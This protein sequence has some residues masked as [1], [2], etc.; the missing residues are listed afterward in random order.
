[1]AGVGV[2][3]YNAISGAT[4]VSNTI[5]FNAAEGVW[6]G[7]ADE[8]LLVRNSVE[9]NGDGIVIEGA[10]LAQAYANHISNNVI[11]SND[12][13]GVVV[14][15]DAA[16]GNTIS[17]NVITGNGG[18][19]ISLES[20][21]NQGI[22]AP[23]INRLSHRGSNI[24]GTANAADGSIVEVFA[25]LSDEGALFLGQTTV[26]GGY[27][28][29]TT[30]VPAGMELHATVS[31]PDGN[32]SEFGPADLYGPPM[33]DTV[34]TSTRDGNEEIYLM[35]SGLA[36][37]RRLTARP[38]ADNN[39]RLCK[40]GDEVVFASDALGS[41]DIWWVNS[42]G[43]GLEQLTK[44]PGSEFEPAC[45]PAGDQLAYS[46]GRDIF[47]A[48][49]GGAP[50]PQELAY[51]DG[52][53][54]FGYGN[55]VGHAYGVH[56]TRPAAAQGVDAASKPLATLR[57]WI[58]ADPAEFQWQVYDWVSGKPGAK[59][60][61]GRTT[62]T[63]TGWHTVELSGV[64]VNQD[65]LVGMRFTQ[66]ERPQLGF[67]FRQE[68]SDRSWLDSGG[69]WWR[70]PAPDFIMIRAGFAAGATRL[71]D[72]AFADRQPDWCA[73]G[74]RIAFTSNRGGNDDIWVIDSDGANLRRVTTNP[75]ADHSPAWSPDCSQ[76]AFV[77]ERDGN[78]EIY[79]IDPAG[80]T[81]IR[82]TDHPASDAD[83]AWLPDGRK[84]LFVSDRDAEQEI[85]ITDASGGA[86]ERLTNSL[87][88]NRQPDAGASAARVQAAGLAA[89]LSGSAG[90]IQLALPVVSVQPGETFTVPVTLAAAQNLGLLAFDLA[91]PAGNL[92]LLR[93]VPGP[94]PGGDLYAVN[95]E[96]IAVQAGR[97]R[98]G[99]VR[100]SGFTGG[101]ELLRLVFRAEPLAYGVWP[102]A[103]A[104]PAAFDVTLSVLAMDVVDGEVGAPWPPTPTVA[105]SR[106]VGDVLL[107]WTHNAA[108]AG[109][110][111]V[112]FSTNP[113]FTPGADC[114]NPPAGQVCV[115]VSAPAASYRHAGAAADVVNNYAYQV[116]GLNATGQRSAVSN[117][118]AEFGF[119]LTPGT[120]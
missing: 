37:A 119:G 110:Y 87:G 49:L 101:G 112:W 70:L 84:L 12:G 15:G 17:R 9:H 72:D 41:W 8:T 63:T 36:S 33:A 113:Y 91:Y 69:G 14:A 82:I 45:S 47:V 59:I 39:P 50:S 78:P 71:T 120:P 27:F 5:V 103:F 2:A 73:D 52:G 95:P 6:L 116:F 40:N 97:I 18:K 83:P 35:G 1:M 3:L 7:S 46:D 102:L 24:E 64:E 57:F 4:I 81:A 10:F 58:H 98:F 26:R 109:G 22:A 92:T 85:Y 94:L 29:L 31:D 86:L 43:T 75:A 114:S 51:D 104:S 54:E 80:A 23:I 20:G 108:N 100:A 60:A 32:T 13:A 19:G 67:D 115:L 53:A 117:R 55:P 111:Q 61:E 88:D 11:R 79:R 56:F 93:I 68:A 106:D 96:T 42:D 66:N 74:R 62:P 99:W 76:I 44:D 107:T 89:A 30:Q 28:H 65:F 118:V 21:G 77:S 25:D 48:A 90:P 38:A 16:G 105:A 34:F